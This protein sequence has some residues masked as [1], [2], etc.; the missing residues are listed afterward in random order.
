MTAEPTTNKTWTSADY[1]AMENDERHE[2]LRGVLRMVPAP[3]SA[4]QRAASVLGSRLLV[5]IED[6]D[7][8][9][10]FHAPFDVV[11]SDDTV[12]QPDFCFVS[13]ERFAELHDGHGLKGAPDLVVEVLSPSTERLDRTS[14]RELYA[15]AGVAWLLFVD[16]AEKLVEVFR[17]NDDGQYVVDASFGGDEELAIGLFDDFSLPLT[18]LWLND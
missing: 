14:K 11:L 6:H 1:M 7:L 8:G 5:F 18:S 16:P 3:T 15:E 17:L 10:A 13:S 12:V 2:L 4:H 9:L